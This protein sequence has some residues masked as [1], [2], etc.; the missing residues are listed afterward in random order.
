MIPSVYP[1][2][3]QRFSFFFLVL[4]FVQVERKRNA[5][6]DDYFPSFFEHVFLP[7]SYMTEPSSN[8]AIF[9]RIPVFFLF[10]LSLVLR[11]WSI[12]VFLSPSL[13]FCYNPLFL[14]LIEQRQEH[15]GKTISNGGRT[16]LLLLLYRKSRKRGEEGLLSGIRKKVVGSIGFYFFPFHSP[17]S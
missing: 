3:F 11:F 5:N 14:Y 1:L 12:L 2:N 10:S 8:L 6:R 9:R 16:F 13:F 4:L 17:F 7:A 15:R